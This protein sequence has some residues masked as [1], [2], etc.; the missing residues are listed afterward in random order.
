MRQKDG[1]KNFDIKEINFSRDDIN[2]KISALSEF[3]NVIKTHATPDNYLSIYLSVQKNL[4][5]RRYKILFTNSYIKF[6]SQIL[7][8]NTKYLVKQLNWL[9]GEKPINK[10]STNKKFRR[11]DKSK[12]NKEYW[13]HPPGI[14]H[15]RSTEFYITTKSSIWAVKKK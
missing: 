15:K 12:W 4:Y 6:V 1:K 7:K 13:D 9:K 5:N 3:F 11:V 8:L 10:T 14:N 2:M